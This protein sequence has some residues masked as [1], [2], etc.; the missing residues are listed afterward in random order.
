MTTAQ[1]E[2]HAGHEKIADVASLRARQKP[3]KQRYSEDAAAAVVTS[4]AS[5]RVLGDDI[6]A[7]LDTDAGTIVAGL[8]PATGG[9]GTQACSGDIVLQA[10]VAC[11]AVTLKSVAT[12]MRVPLRS[13]T[14]TATGEWDARGTL[15][16]AKDV[17]VGFTSVSVV[18]DLDTDADDATIDRLLELTERYCVVAQTLRNPPEVSVERA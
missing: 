4:R 5:A 10:L 2:N 15:G 11:A 12:A 18:A 1:S 3:L 6:A 14:L 9:D 7:E 13:A 8:H 16:V 17:P